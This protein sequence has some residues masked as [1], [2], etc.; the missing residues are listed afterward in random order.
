[1]SAAGG[2]SFPVKR[3]RITPHRRKST[4]ICKCG[5]E[6]KNPRDGY[7]KACRKAASAAGRA[8]A[9][10]ELKRL[11][12]LEEQQKL[13]KGKDNGQEKTESDTGTTQ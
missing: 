12:A 10:A 4:G 6:R 13:S 2:Q 7:C 3:S 9:A 11:R 1:M 8:K 5:A